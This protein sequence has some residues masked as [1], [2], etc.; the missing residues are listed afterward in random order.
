MKK[1]LYTGIVAM[2][3][4]TAC[5]DYN[6]K[7]F[8]D[9][10]EG[11]K[12]T[13]IKKLEYTLT[14]ADY[15][16]IASLSAN[17]TIAGENNEKNDLKQIS[18]KNAF[19][20]SITAAK[21]VPAFLDDKYSFAD[22]TSAIKVTY[23]QIPESPAYLS[24][25][26]KA[27]TYTLKSADYKEAWAD[28]DV[29]YFTPARPAAKYLPKILKSAISGAQQ[30]DYAVAAY[31]YSA[32]EPSQ[33][34]SETVVY[35]KVSDVVSGPIGEY[36]VKGTVMAA[37]SRGF[38]LSD[39]TASILVYL[40]KASNYTLGD[41][42]TVKG[43]VSEYSGLKQ[44]PNTSEVKWV[45][46]A[47]EAFTYPSAVSMS[48]ADMDAYLNNITVKYVSYIGKLTLSTNSSGTATYYNITDIEGTSKAQ[49]SVSYP[50]AG[51]IDSSLDGKMVVVTGYTIGTSSSKY[52][53]TMATSVV[54]V[55]GSSETYSPVATVA[56]AAPG[57]YKVC[58]VVAATYKSGFLLN[59]GTGSILVYKN[60]D[61]TIGDVMTVSGATNSY[62][63]LNQYKNPAIEKVGESKYYDPQVREL[64]GVEMDEYLSAPYVQ[65][66]SFAGKLN[67][68]TND[69]GN[70]YY[71]IEDIEGASTA[72]GSLSYPMDGM[73]DETLNG[74]KVIVTGYSIGAT[75]G[76][77]VTMMVTKVQDATEA[78]SLMSRAADGDGMYAVYQFDGSNWNATDV[79][80][81]SPVDYEKMGLTNPNFSSSAN[82]DNYLPQ[83]LSLNYPYAQNETVKAVAYHYYS[84][85]TTSLSV[86][87]YKFE[88]GQ[89]I[90]ATSAIPVTD[91]FVK[92]NGEWKYNPSVVL[93]LTAGR[94]QPEISVY[95]QAIVD[96][97]WEN[98]DQK[99]LGVTTKGQG[100]VT[101]FAAPTGSE[102]YFG[103]T[104]YQ[105]NIDLRPGK[106]LEQY[107]KGY[108]GMSDEQ[109]SSLVMERL[110]KAFEVALEAVHSA[111]APIDGVDITYTVKFAI[112]DG[113]STKYW[114]S[115]YKVVGIGDFE[116]VEDSMKAVE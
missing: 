52:V 87:E 33:G 104:A 23:N 47:E 89:W 21:Y 28:A 13:D 97:V 31:N 66:V 76:K 81:V 62:A 56:T 83:F 61:Y 106:F 6:E 88:G 110:P 30:G 103:A 29:S 12:P 55:D 57:D 34:G 92:S 78:R 7:Y 86:M 38:L 48:G 67:I 107:A 22:N 96:W 3:A 111:V 24:D 15:A 32:N 54:A 63:G 60:G 99:E 53:N 20:A 105:N 102:Y 65:Y 37:Y 42:V 41:M 114:Q 17:E 115:V 49:G 101:S 10:D 112:Y 79:A 35:D 59:D 25:V 94:S 51:L 109:I 95:Y 58:G 74:K 91:Q 68:T 69:K 71:N 116:Y 84:G 44:F 2:L 108:E 100:Y 73:V 85:E 43:T 8:G 4:L 64:T 93:T 40:N 11:L 72:I 9:L 18:S 70:K 36:N 80:I 46:G 19:F 14:E 75:S 90:K 5:D 50:A 113:L 98:I 82:P 39:G 26:A 77:F 1:Y 16:T 45:S 27:Q